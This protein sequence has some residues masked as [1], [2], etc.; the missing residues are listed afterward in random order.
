MQQMSLYFNTIMPVNRVS[1][2]IVQLADFNYYKGKFEKSLNFRTV[3][4]IIFHAEKE[5]WLDLKGSTCRPKKS[6]QR[7]ERKIIKTVYDSPQSSTRRLA[8]QVE[9]D[10]EL[11]GAQ[12]A[13]RNVL[14]KHK[15]FFKSGIP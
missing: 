8:L 9:K 2:N 3:F 15:Y 11:R 10:L 1:K 12:E 13:I 5:R 7:V 4:N 6:T 14:E